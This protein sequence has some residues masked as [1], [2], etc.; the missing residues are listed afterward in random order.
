MD[1]FKI[2]MDWLAVFAAA[3]ALFVFWMRG[4]DK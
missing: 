4:V 3:L 2:V 1:E